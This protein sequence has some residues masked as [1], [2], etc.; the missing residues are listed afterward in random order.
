MA[1]IRTGFLS[2]AEFA[3]R[4]GVCPATV[5]R[6]DDKGLLKAAKKN[7]HGDRYYTEDQVN[8]YFAK[9]KPNGK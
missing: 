6:W 2:A 5:R 8:T 1:K 9:Q 4:I 7:R 3:K